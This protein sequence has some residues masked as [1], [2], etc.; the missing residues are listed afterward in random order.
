MIGDDKLLPFRDYDEHEVVNLFALDGLATAGTLVTASVFNPMLETANVFA[1]MPI[2]YQHGSITSY[3]WINQNKVVVST[4][5][6]TRYDVLGLT[7]Y[8][9]KEVNEHNQALIY[10]GR[11][12]LDAKE[13]VLSGETVPIVRRGLFRL[14]PSAYLGTPAVNKVGVAG[15]N[16]VIQLIDRTDFAF[17]GVAGTG[18]GGLGGNLKDWHVVGKCISTTGTQFS[19]NCYFILD[20]P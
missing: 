15:A 12:E 13:I 11:D 16:G 3:R 18:V 6:H 19:G 14:K 9:V 2:G 4:S 10:Q 20:L 7:L 8:D 17:T 1:T 5:G